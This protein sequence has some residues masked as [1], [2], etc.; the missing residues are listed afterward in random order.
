MRLRCRVARRADG[1]LI[2]LSPVGAGRSLSTASLLLS[3][4][5]DAFADYF[6]ERRKRLQSVRLPYGTPPLTPA[7]ILRLVSDEWLRMDKDE[8]K[9]RTEPQSSDANH[10][11]LTQH[12]VSCGVQRWLRG[13]A[14][15]AVKG[16][17]VLGGR[18][19][20]TEG[21]SGK[22]RHQVRGTRGL[23]RS[24]QEPHHLGEGGARDSLVAAWLMWGGWHAS[25]AGCQLRELSYQPWG[26]PRCPGSALRLFLRT[27]GLPLKTGAKAYR[28]LPE[29]ERMVGRV[30]SM[31]FPRTGMIR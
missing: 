24:R 22:Q 26:G 2:E 15:G 13:A 20:R 17:K 16:R 10:P 28:S 14:R 4:S 25:C 11:G 6:A 19:E 3:M 31:T 30:R 7:Q 1:H 27:V 23:T 5:T 8:K 21:F 9:V 18:K 29:E 12:G